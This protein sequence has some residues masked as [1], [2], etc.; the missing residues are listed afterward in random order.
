MPIVTPLTVT[1]RA[2][3]SFDAFRYWG[4]PNKNEDTNHVS[5]HIISR[6]YRVFRKLVRR[7][8][9]RSLCLMRG[10]NGVN[11]GFAIAPKRI[12]SH[13]FPEAFPPVYGIFFI[14]PSSCDFYNH[15]F[16]LKYIT[17]KPTI[18]SMTMRAVG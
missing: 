8:A 6:P 10:L 15:L 11:G 3:A 2:G 7:S 5:S 16:L 17:M 9:V 1:L 12:F 4:N 18:T 13:S 14:K